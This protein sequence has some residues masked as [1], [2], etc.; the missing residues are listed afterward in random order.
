MR[1]AV[2]VVAAGVVLLGVGGDAATRAVVESRV[3]DRLAC[4][5]DDPQVRVGG[6][7]VVTQLAGGRLA[8]VT[9]AAEVGFDQLADLLGDAMPAAAGEV[10]WS[11]E[12]GLLVAHPADLPASIGLALRAEDG[13]LVIEPESVLI[14]GLQVPVA[15]LGGRADRMLGDLLEPRVLDPSALLDRRGGGELGAVGGLGFTE[16]AVTSDA[17]RLTL[18]ATDVPLNPPGG[19]RD[20]GSTGSTGGTAGPDLQGE[21]CPAL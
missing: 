20:P 2:L 16:V 19:P 4:V 15:A 12:N 9:V 5:V 14:G 18:A 8:R 1:R 11:G 21:P 7:P 13:A 3:A 10:A 6:W 17:V